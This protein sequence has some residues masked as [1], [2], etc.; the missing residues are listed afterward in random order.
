MSRLFLIPLLAL[1]AACTS[2]APRQV[3]QPVSQQAVGSDVRNR[4]R[5]HTELG[6]AYYEAK[7]LVAALEEARVALDIDSGYALA[8]NLLGLINLELKDNAQA[9]DAFQRALSIA[10]GD[11]DISNN[12]GWFLC[13][14]GRYAKAMS[15]FET[16]MRNPLYGTPA[17]TMNNA[18]Q[19]AAKNG[20]EAL[21]ETFLQRAL[22]L[23]PNNLRSLFL[24]ADLNYRTGRIGEAR[25]RLAEFHR[26][27]E[28]TAASAWLGLRIARKS[29]DRSEEARYFSQLRQ[30]FPDSNETL[31]L[32]QGRF[33]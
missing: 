27:T 19:C 20:D 32:S 33:E 22:R 11:P 21:A 6:F 24:L 5:I 31:L 13:E 4:A 10:P 17:L 2:T 14:T 1:L 28:M 23:D 9:E 16:A 3:V 26:K 18:A 15:Y 12:Y 25:L 30:R 29:G 8:Y 7:N